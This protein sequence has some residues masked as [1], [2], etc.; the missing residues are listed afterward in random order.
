MLQVRLLRSTLLYGNFSTR[1]R[2]IKTFTS[3]I[4]EVITKKDINIIERDTD[5]DFYMNALSA[6]EYGL[7]DEILENN[8][9]RY[10]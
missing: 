5:R 3:K 9:K 7:I 10:D 2:L 8:K 1:K 4:K 6:K